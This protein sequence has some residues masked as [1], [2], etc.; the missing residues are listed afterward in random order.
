MKVK[1]NVWQMGF[2]N[3]KAYM[4]R[5][6]SGTACK[7]RGYVL[8]ENS[9]GWEEEV[10]NLLNWSCWNY[11]EKGDAVKPED[12]HS[13]LDHCNADIIVQIDGTSLYKAAQFSGFKDFHTL[14]DAVA[15][16]K[17]HPYELW[18]LA[19]TPR[20]YTRYRTHGTNVFGSN[21]GETWHIIN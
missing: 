21:D 4:L 7:E 16:M 11:N 10:W 20:E 12:V 2:D 3:I 14:E 8:V 1:V 18:P 9:E 13:S 6:S 17:K 15:D 5:D 19:E